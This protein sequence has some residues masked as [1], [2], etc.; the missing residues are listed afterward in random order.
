MKMSFL[1]LLY[2]TQFCCTS[3]VQTP[4][5]YSVEKIEL[6]WLLFVNSFLTTICSFEVTHFTR[7]DDALCDDDALRLMT[8][9]LYQT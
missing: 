6:I 5:I 1:F 3:K 4:K 7:P 2:P 9:F 8:R